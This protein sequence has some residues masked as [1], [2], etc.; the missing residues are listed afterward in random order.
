MSVVKRIGLTRA[1]ATIVVV[2]A[3]A[4]AKGEPR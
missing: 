3:L 4:L 1:S 2:L